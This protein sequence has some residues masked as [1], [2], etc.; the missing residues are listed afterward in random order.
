MKLELASVVDWGEV[1]LRLPIILREM[2]HW[3]LHAMKKYKSLLQWLGLDIHLIPRLLFDLFQHKHLHS[4][5]CV[6]MLKAV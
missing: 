4:R 3:L 6:L 1:S 5:D 2:A